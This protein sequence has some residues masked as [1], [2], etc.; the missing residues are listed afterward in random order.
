MVCIFNEVIRAVWYS[1][2]VKISVL[3]CRVSMM[4]MILPCS[5][6]IMASVRVCSA[7]M[8]KGISGKRGKQEHEKQHSQNPFQAITTYL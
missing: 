6:I 2:A 4:V 1:V 3:V 5:M 7:G 8:S